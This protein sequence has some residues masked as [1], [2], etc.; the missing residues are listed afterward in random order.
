MGSTTR[1]TAPEQCG[2]LHSPRWHP[3]HI[4]QLGDRRATVATVLQSM[5]ECGWIHPACHGIQDAASPT[6]NTFLLADGR[7]TFHE[8]MKQYFSYTQLAVLSACQTA[9]GHIELSEE[10]IHLAAG[11]LVAGYGNVVGQSGMTTHPWLWRSSTHISLVTPEETV[12]NRVRTPP[13][14]GASPQCQRREQFCRLSL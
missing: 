11:M 2:S 3:V 7:L 8:I 4:S 13:C 6:D 9:K 12:Q 1:P 5:K 10:T 14:N